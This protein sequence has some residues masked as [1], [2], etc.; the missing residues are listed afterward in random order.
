MYAPNPLDDSKDKRLAGDL[1][2]RQS[3]VGGAAMVI[4]MATTLLGPLPQ[5]ARPQRIVT[6]LALMALI[7][8]L[9]VMY[10]T[11]LADEYVEKTWNAGTSAAFVT[12][13]ALTFAKLVLL[14][15]MLALDRD[16]MTLAWIDVDGFVTLNL[17]VLAFF[18][19]VVIKRYRGV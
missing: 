17:A 9:I 2:M 3:L 18:A 4:L 7:Y 11:R 8:A 5:L 13:L 12:M 19:A 15:G 14:T 1:F 10:R 16:P 6:G